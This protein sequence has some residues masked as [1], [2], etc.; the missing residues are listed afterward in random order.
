MD[1]FDATTTNKNEF[2]FDLPVHTDE[3]VIEIGGD[4]DLFGLD[5][6][7]DD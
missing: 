1:A 6:F 4:D 3:G 5:V 7:S 2:R